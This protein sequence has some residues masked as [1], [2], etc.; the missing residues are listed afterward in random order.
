MLSCF[1]SIFQINSSTFHINIYR[2]SMLTCRLW[3]RLIDSEVNLLTLRYLFVNFEVFY[4]PRSLFIVYEVYFWPLSIIQLCSQFI[5]FEINL[6]T[7]IFI[8]HLCKVSL[9]TPKSTYRLW[10]L[11]V[12]SEVSLSNLKVI[13]KLRSQLLQLFF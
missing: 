5:C 10:S 9:S 7:L 11:L 1:K 12:D 2:L 8:Y 3:N 13:L 4:P 6:W